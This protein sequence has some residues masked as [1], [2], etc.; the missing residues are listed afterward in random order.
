MDLKD[1]VARETWHLSAPAQVKPSATIHNSLT[2]HAN[3]D[4]MRYTTQIHLVVKITRLLESGKFRRFKIAGT[5]TS[6]TLEIK[7]RESRGEQSTFSVV[8]DT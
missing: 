3:L 7:G 2:P 4:L 8:S 1:N 5:K 6:D